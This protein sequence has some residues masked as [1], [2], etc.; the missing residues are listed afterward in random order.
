MKHTNENIGQDELYRRHI[1]HLK[2]QRA[3]IKSEL[4]Y[5]RTK[6]PDP[7]YGVHPLGLAQHEE[8]LWHELDYIRECLQANEVIHQW[9]R[10]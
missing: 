9:G 6:Y 3:K 1:E 8:N 7:D 2:A 4:E 5:L 10:R